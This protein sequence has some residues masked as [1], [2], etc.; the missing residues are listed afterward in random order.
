MKEKS[1]SFS[2]IKSFYMGFW[3]FSSS[4]KVSHLN[5]RNKKSD[6]CS[7]FI[8]FCVLARATFWKTTEECLQNGKERSHW[9]KKLGGDEGG[10]E[11]TYSPELSE[12]ESSSG[13]VQI[14]LLTTWTVPVAAPVTTEVPKLG[15]LVI[16]EATPLTVFID[17]IWSNSRPVGISFHSVLL[18]I[19][20][21]NPRVRKFKQ[22][23]RGV[24]SKGF[25]HA[26]RKPTGEAPGNFTSN[27]KKEVDR[28]RRVFPGWFWFPQQDEFLINQNENRGVSLY[29]V[30]PTLL[31]GEI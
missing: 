27:K 6:A 12:N 29:R 3:W 25:W 9:P 17:E 7:E 28:A 15:K 20:L 31:G 23:R 10:G 2:H 8:E 14:T 22:R 21:E 5:Q 11:S 24:A 30:L 26:K 19:S 4:K 16:A 13:A 18:S 1:K